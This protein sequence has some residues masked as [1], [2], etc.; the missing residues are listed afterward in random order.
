MRPV[1]GKP[2]PNLYG[3]RS[4]YPVR[5]S[6]AASAGWLERLPRVWVEGEIAE[7]KERPA[8]RSAI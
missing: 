4:V 5:G 1:S 8:G 2:T 3:E 6:T 7:L